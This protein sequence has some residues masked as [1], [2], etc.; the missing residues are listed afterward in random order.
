MSNRSGAVLKHIK[1][2]FFDL[3]LF[4][5]LGSF[6]F[7]TNGGNKHTAELIFT[8][9]VNHAAANLH[10]LGVIMARGVMAYGD[11]VGS[12]FQLGQTNLGIIRIGDDTDHAAFDDP[13][14]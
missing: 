2:I 3:L 4:F 7:H 12:Q 8:W 14:T 1:R 5:L 10:C 9:A 13:E 6:C 11:H